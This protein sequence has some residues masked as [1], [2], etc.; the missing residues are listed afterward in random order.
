MKTRVILALVC[1]ALNASAFT[2]GDIVSIDSSTFGRLLP[3]VQEVADSNKDGLL[4]YDEAMAVT[5]FCESGESRDAYYPF[6]TKGIGYFEN[7]Q[8]IVLDSP[9]NH[10][11]YSMNLPLDLSGLPNLKRFVMNK[12]LGPK[13]ELSLSPQVG[14]DLD[15]QSWGYEG[16]SE[17]VW[18]RNGYP[19]LMISNIP[20]A[21]GVNPKSYFRF[22]PNSAMKA[23]A[24]PI[25][26]NPTT[27]EKY[28]RTLYYYEVGPNYADNHDSPRNK[29]ASLLVVPGD[30]VALDEENFPDPNFR[31][32]VARNADADHDGILTYDEMGSIYSLVNYEVE[33][34]DRVDFWMDKHFLVN[35][36]GEHVLSPDVELLNASQNLKGIEYLHN[37]RCIY[38]KGLDLHSGIDMTY[39]P[40]NRT[41]HTENCHLLWANGNWMGFD[42]EILPDPTE[43]D[44]VG[45]KMS[46]DGLIHDV[47]TVQSHGEII[48]VADNGYYKPVR[49]FSYNVA[50]E[51][52]DVTL[53]DDCLDLSQQIAAGMDLNRISLLKG[54]K[55]EDNKLHFLEDEVSYRYL[56]RCAKNRAIFLSDETGKIGN[57]DES[58]D[59]D[60]Y[61]PSELGIENGSATSHAP[62]ILLK[63]TLTA[64]NFV[65]VE[66]NTIA[67]PVEVKITGSG[68]SVHIEG[69]SEASEIMV[70]SPSG[71]V[72]Y[73]G[74]SRDITLP[75]S[76]I[77]IVKVGS[78]VKKIKVVD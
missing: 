50:E 26:T 63:V 68:L 30:V 69:G 41:F 1:V 12:A 28:Y 27:G 14:S 52:F 45:Y 21:A 36:E 77:Y 73:R 78:S 70:A 4:S 76:G 38:L 46:T 61:A 20:T 29:P 59:M 5:R 47:E 65:G 34:A 75:S 57:E 15:I 37:L 67:A 49:F 13:H 72:V 18:K 10:H 58:R 71:S 43:K 60:K 25:A 66:K 3:W 62:T 39:T 42:L 54:A 64:N 19:D 11:W 24:N 23:A 35:E 51:I 32:W 8:E 56:V 17:D 16:A 40:N 22:H 2:Q 7:L 55:I 53:E 9:I 31:E 6:D 33:E 44:P 48:V 74:F